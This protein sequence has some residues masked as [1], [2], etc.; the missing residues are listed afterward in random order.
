MGAQEKKMATFTFL[1]SDTKH[2][3]FEV[4][5][6]EASIS[7][8]NFFCEFPKHLT[9]ASMIAHAMRLGTCHHDPLNLI[10]NEFSVRTQKCN[11]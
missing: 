8:L 3:R 4:S 5:N 1:A 10:N 2:E 7:T 11:R 9:N 6:D